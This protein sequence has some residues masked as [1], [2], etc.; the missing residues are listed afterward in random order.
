M[1]GKDVPEFLGVDVTF[2]V[3][4]EKRE[5]LIAAGIYGHKKSFTAFRC[6]MPS[7]QQAAYTWYMNIAMPHL[8]TNNILQYTQCIACGDQEVALNSSVTTAIEFSKPS[9]ASAKLRLD[10][11][12]FYRKQW[13]D[14]VVIKRHDTDAA[15]KHV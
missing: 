1:N 10:M 13:N 12:N 7:K 2:G 5:L 15:K 4:K 11:Y 8:L 6:F 3:N 14:L 9:F